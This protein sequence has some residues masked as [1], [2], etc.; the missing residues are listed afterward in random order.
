MPFLGCWINGFN[1]LK[2]A[3]RLDICP[4][5]LGERVFEDAFHRAQVAN[6]SRDEKDIYDAALQEKRDRIGRASFYRNEGEASGRALG[7]AEGMAE[8]EAR[9]RALGR[10]EG[11]AEGEIKRQGRGHRRGRPPRCWKRA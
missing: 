2:E 9:G 4:E 7:R 3:P 6:L 1:F 10:A 8:G 5:V 11:E